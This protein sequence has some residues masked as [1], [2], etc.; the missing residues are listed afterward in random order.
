MADVVDDLADAAAGDAEV[1][2]DAQWV[3]PWI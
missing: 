1:V 2:G 3:R